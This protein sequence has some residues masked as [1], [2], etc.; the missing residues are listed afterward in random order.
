MSVAAARGNDTLTRHVVYPFANANFLAENPPICIEDGDGVYVSD[1]GAAAISTGRRVF[2]TSM[3][4][5]AAPEI[6]Q[7]IVEQLDRLSFYSTFGNTTNSPSVALADELCRLAAPEGMVRAFFSSGGSGGERSRDQA[8][9][10]ILA[11]RRLAAAHQDHLAARGL[12][13]RDAGRAFGR[14]RQCLQGAI[15]APAAGILQVETPHVYR[16]RLRR[17]RRRL[18]VS[19]PSCSSARSSIRGRTVSRPSWPSRCRGPAESSCRRRIS[20]RWYARS[21]TGTMCC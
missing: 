17:I 13:W 11:A 19:A 2:G 10:A 9:Q 5:M 14:G 20:G 21:A 16:N 15:H 12:S 8:R 1:G 6:K 7:A 3:S 18:A 4:D